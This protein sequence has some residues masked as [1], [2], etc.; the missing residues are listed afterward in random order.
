MHK[1][2]GR[3][4]YGG[5]LVR[6]IDSKN[7]L[8]LVF[9]QGPQHGLKG[10]IFAGLQTRW[11]QSVGDEHFEEKKG[12]AHA[13][14]D[15]AHH[16]F[17]GKNHATQ[18]DYK[19]PLRSQ[20]SVGRMRIGLPIGGDV[21]VE[22]VDHIGDIGAALDGIGEDD[23]L[24]LFAAEGRRWIKAQIIDNVEHCIGIFFNAPGAHFPIR[25]NRQGPWGKFPILP[26]VAAIDHDLIA[27]DLVA[28]LLGA[29]SGPSQCDS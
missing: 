16:E 15:K 8:A 6:Q 21:A 23:L 10:R 13:L 3:G 29:H 14:L 26:M 9:A 17:F 5:L 22:Q 12:I 4:L 28:G 1:A 25:R 24:G 2:H 20:V 7:P 18:V 11:L 27:A 19:P